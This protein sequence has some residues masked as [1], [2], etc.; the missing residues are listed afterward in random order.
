MVPRNVVF[1]VLALE[2]SA[3]T[4][5][6]FP[7]DRPPFWELDLRKKMEICSSEK[8]PKTPELLMLV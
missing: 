8:L 7:V 3:P 6:R 1:D 5:G 4:S 2:L